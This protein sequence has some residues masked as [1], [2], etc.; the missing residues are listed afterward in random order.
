[1]FSG[2]GAQALLRLLVLTLLARLLGPPEFGLAAAATVVIAFFRLFLETGIRPALIQ[3]PELDD[4][5][6]ST[7]FTLSILIGLVGGLAL[8]AAADWIAREGFEMPP[9]AP[10]IQVMALLL[11]IQSIGLVASGLIQ[12]DLDFGWVVRSEILSYVIGYAP[13]GI[14]MALAGY[15]VWSLVGAYLVQELLRAGISMAVRP[16]SKRLRVDLRAARELLYYGGGF[17]VARV[18][19]WGAQN[20]DKWVAGRWLGQEALGYYKYAFEL[21]AMIATVFG[22]V[23][24]KV[25]F[26]AMARIQHD[27]TRLALVYRRGV[28]LIGVTVYPISAVLF[29]LAPEIVQLVLGEGWEAVIAPFQILALALHVRATYTMSDSLA[30]A[31]GA[32]YRRAW[33][34]AVFAAA[35]VALAWLGAPYGLSLLT[36]GVMAAT[37]LN[38]VLM[39]EL[40]ARL[41]PLSLREIVRA[42]LCGLPA[43]ALALG[44]AWSGA[45][46]ARGAELSHA[47]VVVASTAASGAAL[48]VAL[49]LAPGLLLGRDGL[50]SICLLLD[51]AA[52]RAPWAARLPI[53][54]DLVAHADR[55]DPGLP[56]RDAVDR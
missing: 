1:M 31:T 9:L 23:L 50:Q 5:H 56:P 46:L 40:S 7:A 35:V 48:L 53:W 10:V 27:P 52:A 24:D 26:P 2:T 47:V 19:N 54:R 36:L 43:F 33:R 55:F 8:F 20:G 41:A 49:R 44:A 15:G 14:G 29:V 3:R 37:A 12:R 30:R 13:V 17:A 45:A 51:F 22:Q 16:H 25:L 34:Q 4:V 42:H 11:P 18:G 6:V 28:G 38:L 32:V 39:A 21:T